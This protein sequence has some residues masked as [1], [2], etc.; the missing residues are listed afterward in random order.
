MSPIRELAGK[1][2]PRGVCEHYSF[3]FYYSTRMPEYAEIEAWLLDQFGKATDR[4]SAGRYSF[5]LTGPL[6]TF[7][8]FRNEVDAVAFKIRWF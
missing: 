3:A 2:I 5:D 4:Y 1:Y 8:M 6:L 7:V